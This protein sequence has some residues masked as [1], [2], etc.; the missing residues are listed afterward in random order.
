MNL[1]IN[2]PRPRIDAFCKKWNVRELAVF[3]S[4][5]REDFG[6]DSD[7]DLLISFAPDAKVLFRDLDAMERELSE[8]FGRPV[9]L[10]SRRGVEQSQNAMRR[11][12]ILSNL[13]TLYRAA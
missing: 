4:V 6:P 9:D 12:E 10:V 2:I 11:Q 5:L 13:E 8:V 1:P 3:G 7:I